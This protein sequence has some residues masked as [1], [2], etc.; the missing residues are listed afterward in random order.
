MR[1]ERKASPKSNHLRYKRSCS[2]DSTQVQRS[3]LG[4]RIG[5]ASV[6]LSSEEETTRGDGSP[7]GFR[8][9]RIRQST[10]TELR[11]FCTSIGGADEQGTKSTLAKW[12]K[13]DPT[14][15]TSYSSK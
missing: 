6:E 9:E 14:L 11:D 8:V 12:G 10:R 13:S 7:E 4:I 15:N 5:R 3:S 1:L 2:T